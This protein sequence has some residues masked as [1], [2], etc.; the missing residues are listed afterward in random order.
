MANVTLLLALL[1]L[2]TAAF[3][4]FRYRDLPSRIR[5]FLGEMRR[6][7]NATMGLQTYVDV[8]HQ[9]QNQASIPCSVGESSISPFAHGNWDLVAGD[10]VGWRADF[11]YK[12]R[13]L[14]THGGLLYATITGPAPD[15]PHGEVWCFEMGRWTCVGGDG[16][17]PW[18]PGNSSVEHLFSTSAG[19]VAAERSGVWL[20]GSG[21]WS[22]LGNGLDQGEKSG[23]YCFA[24]WRGQ[25]IAGHWGVPRVSV[26]KPDSTWRYLPDPRGGWG[27]GARTIYSMAAWNGYLYVGTG[28]GKLHGPSSTVWRFDGNDWEQV[29]GQGIRGSWLAGGIPFVLSLTP[30]NDRLIATLSRPPGMASAASNVWVF[31]GVQWGALNPGRVPKLMADSLI[32][33]DSVVFQDRLVVATGHSTRAPAEIWELANSSE[34]KPVGPPRLKQHGSGD[35]GWWIYKLCTDGDH[36]YASTAGHRGAA[37]ILRFSPDKHR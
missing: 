32:M 31:D 5:A 15:G 17:G 10:G 34:W 11:F 12:V 2:L 25:L 14:A 19:L 26:M 3:L 21:G 28:T 36:L 27:A 29:A 16:I 9:I 13:G 6:A 35:G 33:N 37:T 30:F 18:R 20:L 22:F 8:L 1:L 4:C 23:P 24:E 7:A